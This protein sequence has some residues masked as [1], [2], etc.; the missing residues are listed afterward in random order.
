MDCITGLKPTKRGNTAIVV[1]IDAYSKW[2]DARAI[3]QPNSE[4]TAKF[5]LEE[6]IS[7]T[8]AP[9]G[10][11]TDNDPEFRKEF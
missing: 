1:A 8:G 9:A 6:I 10:V 7:K 4:L 11:R 5:F 2:V 3:P